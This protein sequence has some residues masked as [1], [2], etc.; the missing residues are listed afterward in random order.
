MSNLFDNIQKAVFGAVTDTFGYD[1]SWQPSDAS[2]FTTGRVLLK[3]PTNQSELGGIEYNP[4]TYIAE[5]HIPHFEGLK[6][7][8][9]EGRTETL[10]INN[11]EYYVRRV[12]AHWDGKTFIAILEKIT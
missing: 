3:E 8:A 9:D 12:D 6:K 7:A 2:D 4:T 1:A 10:T 11:N 5:Y